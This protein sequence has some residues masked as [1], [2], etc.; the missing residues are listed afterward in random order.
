VSKVESFSF[1][2]PVRSP[3]EAAQSPSVPEAVRPLLGPSWLVEGEDPKL[4]EELLGEVGAAVGAEDI[5]DW[6]LVKD[7]VAL[8]WQTHRSR[9]QCESLIRMA[10]REA[11]ERLLS[12]AL[13]GLGRVFGPGERSMAAK[14]AEDWFNG[15]KNAVKYVHST[16]ARAGFSMADVA[17][18]ALSFKA[19]E[20]ER[21][22]RQN[23]RNDRRRDAIL[24]QI[25]HRRTGWSKLVKQASEGAIEAKF[26]EVAPTD[27]EGPANDLAF[28]EKR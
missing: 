16:L 15:K 25:D 14:A 6:L 28:S 23:E 18:Q 3:S 17:S 22:D 2:A 19:E 8:T 9:R 12:I 11:M 10:R 27:K 24:Q 26:K 1:A 4:F 5:I 13:P 7:Y 20:L 21:I